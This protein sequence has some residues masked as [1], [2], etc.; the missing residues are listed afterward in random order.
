LR[1]PSAAPR[2]IT[3][4]VR[5]IDIF[6]TIAELTGA[7]RPKTLHGDSLWPLIAGSEP[8]A[9][10]YAYSESM[11]TRL[12]YGWSA[13]YSVRTND[14]KYIEAP[15][16]ELYDLR[17]DPG[18]STNRLT[19][20]RRATHE[21]RNALARIRADAAKDAP[22]S[23]EANLDAETVAKLSS[24]GYLGG[25][26][27]AAEDDRDLADPKDKLH[28][29][30]AVAYAANRMIAN[31]YEDAVE[32]LR[33][34]LE[35]DPEVP[36]A[37]LLLVTAYRKTGR[38]TEAKEI[39]DR[40]LRKDAGNPRALIAMAEILSEEGLGEEVIAICK[41]ALA[42]DDHNA[43]AWELMAD[44]YIDRNDH[45]NALPLLRKV[46]EIQPKLTRSRNNLAA[47]LIGVG[48]AD[49]AEK[50]LQEI[51]RDHPR[52]PLANYHPASSARVRAVC[53]RRNR[54]T[55]PKCRASR[56]RWWRASIS[57]ICCSASATALVPSVRCARSS[58][59]TPR[60]RART[61]CSLVRCSIV[62]GA[63]RKRGNGRAAASSERTSTTSR[64]SAISSWP[65]ST[66]AR[67]IGPRWPQPCARLGI[68]S[69]S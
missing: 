8:P 25:S 47:S 43:R 40:F 11:A 69:H 48:R 21:L 58:S 44:V 66:L 27:E 7:A 39:L 1:V 13:L 45:Q 30:E 29:F 33:L 41:R 64:H 35:D 61:S 20:V 53:V 5:T 55:R 28:L 32:S 18:E 24:L 59:R 65:T 60:P 3:A 68:T 23:T 16:A 54:R 17:A 6:P 19:D 67:A 42:E 46:V 50:L 10:R 2:R 26:S 49:E 34:V 15:R 51:L 14:Y 22:K 57:A 31:D 12:Q 63:W 38:T 56:S 52:F 36:Q 4:Q 37:Q 62:P 9:P